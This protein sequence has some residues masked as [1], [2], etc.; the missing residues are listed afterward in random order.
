MTALANRRNFAGLIDLNK[1]FVNSH[2]DYFRKHPSVAS[3]ETDSDKIRQLF[4]CF[5][6][7]SSSSLCNI[8]NCVK[9]HENRKVV[10]WNLI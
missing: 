2:F 1:E 9:I 8:L 7:S 10:N 5:R 3:E 4:L 6:Y